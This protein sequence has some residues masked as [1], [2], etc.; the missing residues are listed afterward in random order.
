V[1]EFEGGPVA[2]PCRPRSRFFWSIVLSL[3]LSVL[4]RFVL[5]L[6]LSLLSHLSAGQRLSESFSSLVLPSEFFRHDGF[7]GRAISRFLILRPCLRRAGL[8]AHGLDPSAIRDPEGQVHRIADD[9]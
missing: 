4:F 8:Y 3:S 6:S 7:S 2:C 1:V 5:S 9:F